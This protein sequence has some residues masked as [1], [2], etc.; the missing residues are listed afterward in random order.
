M[1]LETFGETRKDFETPVNN[2]SFQ[3][4]Y[5]GFRRIVTFYYYY[6]D[7]MNQLM[8]LELT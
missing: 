5:S 4:P 6:F 7:V 1:I 8:T 3:K 2:G